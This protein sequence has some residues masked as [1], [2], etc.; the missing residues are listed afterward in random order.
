[1][2][3]PWL[4]LLDQTTA[5]MLR[6]NYKNGRA[7]IYAKVDMYRYQMSGPLWKLLPQYLSNGGGGMGRRIQWWNRTFAENLIPVVQL[8]DD[9]RLARAT[10][11]G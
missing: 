8:G 7:P 5:E 1:M 10:L 11:G 4:D 9:Q 2:H 6:S 3:R